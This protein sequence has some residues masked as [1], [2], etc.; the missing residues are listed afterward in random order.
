MSST[1]GPNGASATGSGREAVAAP[2]V[3]RSRPQACPSCGAGS[4]GTVTVA[5]PAHL[6]QGDL[7]RLVEVRLHNA[8]VAGQRRLDLRF[9]AVSLFPTALLALSLGWLIGSGG[10][11]AAPDRDRLIAALHNLSGAGLLGLSLL[12]FVVAVLMHPFSA[13]RLRLLEGYWE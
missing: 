1:S 5:N 11:R 3:D 7:T 6:G 13:Q 9:F 2:G 4:A 8:K 10:V 12:V